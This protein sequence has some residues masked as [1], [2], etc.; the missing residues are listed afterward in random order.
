MRWIGIDFFYVVISR[1]LWPHPPEQMVIL[2]GYLK[3]V[4]NIRVPQREEDLLIAEQLLSS[5]D[6]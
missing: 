2:T 4:I 1:L 3:T 5:K 6:G